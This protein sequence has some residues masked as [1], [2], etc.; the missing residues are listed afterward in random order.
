MRNGM[1]LGP[2]ALKILVKFLAQ[3]DSPDLDLIADSHDVVRFVQSLEDPPY[4]S[5]FL[6]LHEMGTLEQLEQLENR[7]GIYITIID[8]VLGNDFDWVEPE[9]ILDN[10]ELIRRSIDL[11]VQFNL[12]FV[13]FSD[14]A[15]HLVAKFKAADVEVVVISPEGSYEGPE[16]SPPPPDDDSG[17]DDSGDDDSGDD[18]SGDDSGSARPILPPTPP[19]TPNGGQAVSAT[20]PDIAIS[21]IAV[22]DDVAVA[23]HGVS[24][25]AILALTAAIPPNSV[26]SLHFDDRSRSGATIDRL[27]QQILADQ[28]ALTES[29]VLTFDAIVAPT[30]AFAIAK[31]AIVRTDLYNFA[32]PSS[33]TQPLNTVI[34]NG[35]SQVFADVPYY[36]REVVWRS[37]PVVTPDE[38]IIPVVTPVVTPVKPDVQPVVTP[39]VDPIVKPIDQPT[40]QPV[41]LSKDPVKPTPIWS[42]FDSGVYTVDTQGEISIDYLWDG[43]ANQ[44]E[45]GI[46]D[47]SGMETLVNNPTAFTEE[48]I[49]RV[50]SNSRL[51]H[52]V[53]SDV[54]E[55]A[56]FSGKLITEP[57]D[58]NSG[59]YTGIKSFD[60]KPGSQFGVIM[61]SQ[62]QFKTLGNLANT[63]GFFFSLTKSNGSAFF[64]SAQMVARSTDRSILQIEDVPI[65]SQR[66]DRDY[67]DLILK[68]TGV[69]GLARSSQ[70]LTQN[71]FRRDQFLV[72]NPLSSIDRNSL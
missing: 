64:R 20:E 63:D 39:V 43:G 66:S 53:L 31:D 71:P 40:E 42:T 7:L 33:V 29:Q 26:L 19:S 1:L 47:L 67:N 72:Q 6:W 41:P 25:L 59:T 21:A 44:G 24:T 45:V 36:Q 8:D 37:L 54:T 60:M 4:I 65:T 52:V 10:D 28:T 70:S 58:F 34:S 30:I 61:I 12:I 27:T 68:I 17:D 15:P 50:L 46:F 69:N 51:G 32:T 22:T 57:E 48:A 38:M 3:L 9:S 62:G 49:H 23:Y 55:G 13:S 18:D 11:C 35:L 14:L 16:D 5:R 56:R 2:S